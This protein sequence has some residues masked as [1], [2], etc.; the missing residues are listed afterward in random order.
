MSNTQ[1][2]DEFLTMYNKLDRA[3]LSLLANIYHQDVVFIDPLHRIDGL[4]E[5]TKYFSNLYENLDAGRFEMKK[6]LQQ[7]NTVSLYWTMY[8]SHSKIKAGKEVSFDGNSYLEYR[9]GKVIF[10]RDYF[11]AADMLYQH[12]PVLGG[13]INLVKKRATA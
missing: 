13:L 4:S 9:D 6:V 11:N 3:N 2:I 12:I 5:L 7:D 1:H 10:H 8:F